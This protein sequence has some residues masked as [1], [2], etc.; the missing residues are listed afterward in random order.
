MSKLPSAGEGS[1]LNFVQV[2]CGCHFA[3]L[4]FHGSFVQNNRMLCGMTVSENIAHRWPPRCYFVY[5]LSCIQRK[6]VFPF[7]P[8]PIR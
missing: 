8:W 2:A 4:S 5:E 7:G 6:K 1:S 3:L